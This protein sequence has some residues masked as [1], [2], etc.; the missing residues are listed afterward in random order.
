VVR[1][2]FRLIAGV[3]FRFRVEGAERVPRSGPGILVAPQ[4]NWLDPAAVGGA[5]PRPV[6]FLIMDSV[7]RKPWARWFY[8]AMRS[9]PVKSGGSSS[10]G[11]LRGALRWLQRGELIG[12]F[13]EGRVVPRAGAG[14]IHA[15]AALLSV[16][17][18]APVIPVEIRGS[19]QAWPHGRSYP[20]PAAVSVHI[21]TPIWPPP[22]EG[23]D[24]VDQ[25]QRRIERAIGED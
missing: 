8:R 25:L 16:R 10:I 9:I 4:R 18:G 22:A 24:A 6:R 19:A 2:L 20:A 14:R 15:G 11:A 12:I 3:A 5:C 13:P 23:P 1:R 21:G 7:Y 17:S